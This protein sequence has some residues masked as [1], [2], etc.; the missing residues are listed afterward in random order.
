MPVRILNALSGASSPPSPRNLDLLGPLDEAEKRVK[1]AWPEAKPS[2]DGGR[3]LDEI[4]AIHAKRLRWQARIATG[5]EIVWLLGKIAAVAI[6]FAFAW[7][8]WMA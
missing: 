5:G 1:E 3:Y 4:R 7:T 6:A 8:Q 2:G